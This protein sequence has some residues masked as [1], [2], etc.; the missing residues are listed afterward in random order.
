MNS[1]LTKL[2]FAIL[3]SFVLGIVGANSLFTLNFDKPLNPNYI[4]YK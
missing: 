1:F 4:E 2:V 3:V